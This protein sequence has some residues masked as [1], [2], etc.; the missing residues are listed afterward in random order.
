MQSITNQECYYSDLAI[1]EFELMFEDSLTT[2]YNNIKEE[3]E[4]SIALK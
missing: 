2:Y 3:I 4:R 1:E